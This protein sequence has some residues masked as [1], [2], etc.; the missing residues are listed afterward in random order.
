MNSRLHH[1]FDRGHW[2]LLPGSKVLR[3][4]ENHKQRGPKNN[5]FTVLYKDKGPFEYTLVATSKM[6]AVPIHRQIESSHRPIIPKAIH[7][8]H[9]SYPFHTFPKI[10]SHVHPR[11]VIFNAGE[12]IASGRTYDLPKYKKKLN[13]VKAI[14]EAWTQPAP[15]P[16]LWEISDDDEEG[17]DEPKNEEED[18]ESHASYHTRSARWDAQSDDGNGPHTGSPPSKRGRRVMEKCD[19]STRTLVEIYEASQSLSPEEKK[20]QDN[21]L[22]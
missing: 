13:A 14:Y 3:K 6:K 2:L 8:S 18:K 17:E 20:I 4:S 15:L 16:G 5:N 19:G 22:G 21:Q 1:A 10:I 7:F 9:H 12:K 11:Y